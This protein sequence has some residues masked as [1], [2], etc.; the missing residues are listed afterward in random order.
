MLELFGLLPPLHAIPLVSTGSL[1]QR[2]LSH[3]IEE[4]LRDRI[5]SFTYMRLNYIFFVTLL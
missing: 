4:T 1:T 3:H 2:K 5:G